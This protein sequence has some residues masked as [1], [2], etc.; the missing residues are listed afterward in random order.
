MNVRAVRSLWES[1]S[2]QTHGKLGFIN[3][4]R[5]A[6]GLCDEQGRDYQDAHGNRVLGKRDFTPEQFCSNSLKA[7]GESLCGYDNFNQWFNPEG[8]AQHS[9]WSMLRPLVESQGGTQALLESTGVGLDPSAFQDINAYS[10]LVSGLMEV[11]VLEGFKNP[12][13]IADQLMP[14]EATKLNGQKVIGLNPL[15]PDAWGRRQPGQQHP[16]TSFGA[17]W[18]ETPETRE[19]ALAID[20]T[21]EVIFYDRTGD[22]LRNAGEIGEILGYQRELEMLDVI[23]GLAGNYKFRGTTYDTYST[24]T[25]LGQ[26]GGNAITNEMLDWTAFQTALLTMS[27]F[28]DPDTARRILVNPNTVLV[29]PGKLKT[30]EL[31]LGSIRTERRY[32]AGAS[33]PQTTSNPLMISDTPGNP[34]SGQFTLLTS[35]LVEQ[36]LTAAAAD[37]GGAL[38]TS[39]ATE[40]WYL[41]E[42]GKAFKYMVNFPLTIQSASPQ[43]Y[44]M[45]DRGIAM[46]FFAS[47]RGIPSV[48]SVHHILRCSQ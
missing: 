20:V 5:H 39:A 18:I 33:T 17:R 11:K 46:S 9:R 2:K 7:L 42:N 10:I 24:S 6:L 14:S 4:S 22:I 47:E 16:R 13:F 19:L 23:L 44:N 27:R 36:R 35:P 30:A 41:V 40:R 34:Y 8:S 43:S 25:R 26:T 32:G 48:W 28:T 3:M 1:M 12:Q 45:I 38:S 15:Y 29:C 37:G 31:I 21:K